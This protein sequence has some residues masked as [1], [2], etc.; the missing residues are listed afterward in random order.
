[1]PERFQSSALFVLRA[2]RRRKCRCASCC[3]TTWALR[4]GLRR[5]TSSR[6]GRLGSADLGSQLSSVSFQKPPPPTSFRAR[7]RSPPR[8]QRRPAGRPQPMI[9]QQPQF[10]TGSQDSNTEDRDK[11]RGHSMPSIQS[12]L[13]WLSALNFRP[14]CMARTR[15]L[16]L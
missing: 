2:E 1:M 5:N 4:A 9:H 16:S 10:T 12:P 6:L 11:T 8:L 7:T 3:V 13:R 15:M 14:L